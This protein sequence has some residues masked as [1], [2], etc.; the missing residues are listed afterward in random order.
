MILVGRPGDDHIGAVVVS[1]DGSRV[2]GIV[3]EQ[4]LPV[5]LSERCEQVL[6][7]PILDLVTPTS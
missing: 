6:G 4:D 7:G 1:T 5:G 2:E 3:S